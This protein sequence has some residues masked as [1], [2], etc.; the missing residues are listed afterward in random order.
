MEEFNIDSCLD[1][2]SENIED[3]TLKLTQDILSLELAKNVIDRKIA[4]LKKNAKDKGVNTEMVGKQLTTLK[5]RMKMKPGQLEEE[6][7]VFDLLKSDEK[8]I[9][10]I[11]LLAT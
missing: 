9:D 2:D 10:S 1:V 4:N 6:E 11:K 7:R 3:L 8:V 5:Y